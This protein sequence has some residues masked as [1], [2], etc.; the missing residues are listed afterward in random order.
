MVEVQ[1]PQILD[2]VQASILDV[3]DL[4]VAKAQPGA[5]RV[6]ADGLC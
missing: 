6:R 2:V 4:V 5:V 3:A 1:L